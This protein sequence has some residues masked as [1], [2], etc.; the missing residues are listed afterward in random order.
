MASVAA[1]YILPLK[2]QRFMQREVWELR[3]RG[4]A[5]P[6]CYSI[7]RLQGM[8]TAEGTGLGLC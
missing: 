8:T 5:S 2:Q 6:C 4:Q 1:M 7:C 3:E